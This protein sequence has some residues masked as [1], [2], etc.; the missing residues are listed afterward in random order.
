MKLAAIYARVSSEQQREQQ[1]IASQTA[2]L[3][4]FARSRELEVPKE[5]VFEDEGYSGAS[6]ERPGVERVCDLAAE[7]QIQVL[8]VYSPDRL[9][10][11]Y[12]ARRALLARRS[13]CMRTRYEIRAQR[14]TIE[15]SHR[16]SCRAWS[17]VRSAVMRSRALRRSPAHRRSITTSAPARMRGANSAVPCATTLASYARTCSIKSYGPR[18]SGCSRIPR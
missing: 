17:A 5:W 7:G 16:A 11:K 13:S 18:S 4:E 14:R 9:S 15:R 8:R 6:L 12:A 3:I 2:A 1:T 10:R